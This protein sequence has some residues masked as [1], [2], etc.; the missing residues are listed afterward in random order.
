[1]SQGFTDLDDEFALVEQTAAEAGLVGG[2]LPRVRRSWV[3][4]PAGGHVS[5]VF[6]GEGQAE[7]VFLHDAG[8]SARAWDTQFS[9]P[10]ALIR[11]DWG[12]P[13]RAAD[14]AVLRQR[15]PHGQVIT[16]PG[17]GADLIATQP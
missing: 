12:G 14:L 5:G 17:A 13:L 16:I 1:M 6:W 4:V 10:V 7:L 15:V 8:E 2:A 3:N 11:G 9:S